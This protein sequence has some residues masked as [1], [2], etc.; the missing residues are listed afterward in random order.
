MLSSELVD[1]E[2]RNANGNQRNTNLKAT[3]P[4]TYFTTALNVF[5]AAKLLVALQRFSKDA[6][7]LAGLVHLQEQTCIRFFLMGSLRVSASYL[8]F[9]AF[10]FVLLFWAFLPFFVDY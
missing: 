8:H 2:Q 7:I 5:F 4:P 1:Q 3:K 9:L 6:D 10:A